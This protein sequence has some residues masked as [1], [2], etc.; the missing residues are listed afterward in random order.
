MKLR[1]VRGSQS[2]QHDIALFL[3]KNWYFGEQ[4]DYL[5]SLP[6]SSEFTTLTGHVSKV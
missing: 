3:K 1:H 6:F 5:N 2:Q 4:L